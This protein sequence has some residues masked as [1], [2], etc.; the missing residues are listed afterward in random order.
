MNAAQ[1]VAHRFVQ[2]QFQRIGDEGVA[3]GDLAHARHRTQEIAEVAAVEVVA[4]VDGEPGEPGGVG[5]AAVAR[6]HLGLLRRA[7]RA[8]IRLGVELHALGAEPGGM[9]HA[10]G[11]GVHEEAHAGAERM[12]LGDQGLQAPGIGG[13]VPAV[14]GGGLLGTVWNEGELVQRQALRDQRSRNV[15]QV[16]ERVALDVEL[17]LGPGLHEQGELA[18]VA[19]ADMPFVGPRMN[20]DAV[21]SGLQHDSGRAR[22]AWHVERAGV[23]QPR[24]L[25][26]VDREPGGA[27][28]PLGACGDERIHGRAGD[29]KR[30]ERFCSSSMSWRV[31][32]PDVGR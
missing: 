12:R 15:H 1:V 27:A 20:R 10:L 32:R 26:E 16:V 3:D 30:V 28:A 9:H 25:V 7:M 6:Q 8:R 29:G 22:D 5:G 23:A 17:G 21:R 11:L 31:R 18:H 13:Q 14:V 2:A 4:G 24:H 19:R